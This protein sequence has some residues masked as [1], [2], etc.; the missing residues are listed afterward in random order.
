MK[1]GLF[2]NAMRIFVVFLNF[3]PFYLG[4]Y[5]LNEYMKN[6]MD[7]RIYNLMLNFF[8]GMALL[9]YWIASLKKPR[10][11]PSVPEGQEDKNIMCNI[12]RAWKPERAHHCQLC[13]ICVPK[14]DHHCPWIGGCVGYH[15]YKPFFL[16]CF[17]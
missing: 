11:I 13:G 8:L 1:K 4:N 14:M 3:C 5:E 17:Y 2:I 12:C 6:S 16:F 10:P 15:N 9:S 7:K